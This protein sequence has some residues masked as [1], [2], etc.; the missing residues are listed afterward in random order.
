[1]SSRK[2]LL[3]LTLGAL[4]LLA[5]L[6][7]Q[8]ARQYAMSMPSYRRARACVRQ[9]VF[10]R[11]R[12]LLRNELSDVFVS[13]DNGRFWR[14]LSEK[15][16]TLTVANGNELWGAHGWPGHHEGPSASIWRSADRG[17]TWS[18]KDV[19]VAK[20]RDA[21]LYSLLPAG[22]VNE[23][24]EPPLLRMS[25]VQIVRP[26]L[27][28]DSSKWK[29]VGRRP[30][31]KLRPPACRTRSSWGSLG[32]APSRRRRTT[33]T[34]RHWQPPSTRFGAHHR[35]S[36]RLGTGLEQQTDEIRMPA[37][38]GSVQSRLGAL[39][40]LSHRRAG[41]RGG[42]GPRRR[43]RGRRLHAGQVPPNDSRSWRTVRIV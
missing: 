10:L 22:F 14:T 1:M 4:S 24:G 28:A 5:P 40:E 17:E 9:I 39:V 8:V 37:P 42:D 32:L 31:A 3:L 34:C 15:P 35:R 29:R 20:A 6:V 23:P 12:I 13:D 11:G 41:C 7:W 27:S 18:N 26:E 2:R 21:A 33:P 30:D 43:L 38:G 16:P 25:D 36:G 19:E